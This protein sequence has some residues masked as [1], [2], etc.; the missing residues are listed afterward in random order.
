MCNVTLA[1]RA[2]RLGP[3]TP[4]ETAW[5]RLWTKYQVLGSWWRSH[6][7][8]R[9]AIAGFSQRLQGTERVLARSEALSS[10][11]TDSKETPYIG[12]RRRF[13]PTD[14]FPD[15]NR[16][17]TSSGFMR[18]LETILYVRKRSPFPQD[19]PVYSGRRAAN[20]RQASHK[21]LWQ[22]GSPFAG[23]LRD[24]G[25]GVE[26]SLQFTRLLVYRGCGRS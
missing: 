1:V 16:A 22:L 24:K 14:L 26:V 5:R 9:I 8:S 23:R 7:T 21:L 19:T 13:R 6:P 11:P 10:S 20:S 2:A 3:L 4:L 12:C 17:G 18:S 15:S 25:C